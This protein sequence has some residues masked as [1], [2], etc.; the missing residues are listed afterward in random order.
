M[1]P[2]TGKAPL[3]HIDV[4]GGLLDSLSTPA[5]VLTSGLWQIN[6]AGGACQEFS[7]SQAPEGEVR[8]VDILRS[9]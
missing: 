1:Q 8:V 4:S 5:E 9:C 2:K 3:R 6:A 7:G